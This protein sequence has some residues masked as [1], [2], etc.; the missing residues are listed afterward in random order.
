MG[1]ACSTHIN[2]KCWSEILNVILDLLKN[3]VYTHK[4]NILHRLVEL[5]VNNELAGIGKDA[6]VTSSKHCPRICLEGLNKTIESISREHS[7]FRI[8]VLKP[9]D[10]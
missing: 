3:A 10:I 8:Q 9:P 1:G 6:V 5:L 7:T 2:D 4:F